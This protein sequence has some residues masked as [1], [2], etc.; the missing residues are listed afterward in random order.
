VKTCGIWSGLVQ[1]FAEDLALFGDNV[2][3][4]IGYLPGRID[5][6]H[7]EIVGAAQLSKATR[8]GARRPSSPFRTTSD[9][10]QRM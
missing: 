8:V 2:A 4:N 10:G 1:H 7:R 9:S 3:Q 5:P 6:F